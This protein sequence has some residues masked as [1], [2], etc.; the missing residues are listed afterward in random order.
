ML[1]T[2]HAYAWRSCPCDQAFQRQTVGAMLSPYLP[3]TWVQETQSSLQHMALPALRLRCQNR[4]QWVMHV[5]FSACRWWGTWK[6]KWL[7]SPGPKGMHCTGMFQGVQGCQSALQGDLIHE[8]H[9]GHRSERLGGDTEICV[10]GH[11]SEF[12]RSRT[13]CMPK[14]TYLVQ[15]PFS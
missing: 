5:L 11:I 10:S 14:V 6:R 7:T 13:L 8:A 12:G 1:I 15:E 4:H 9:T 3:C 2:W